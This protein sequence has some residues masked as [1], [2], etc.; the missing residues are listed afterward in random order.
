MSETRTGHAG[1]CLHTVT[2]RPWPI[3]T[4]IEKY[5]AAGIGGITIWRDAV[6]DRDTAVLRRQIQDAGL[7]VVSLCRGGFFASNELQERNAAL[8]DNRRVIELASDLGAPLVV[9]VCGADPRQ[10]LAD[11]RE[12][13]HDALVTLA[14]YAAERGV[15]LGIEPLHPMYA[16]TRSAINTLRDAR[17]LAERVGETN[18]G[19]VVDV[20]HLW[21]DPELEAELKKLKSEQLFGYHIC[22]WRVPTEHMLTDRGI[23]GEGCIPLA[24]ISTWVRETGFSGFDEVEIFSTRLWSQDQDTVLKRITEAWNG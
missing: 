15:K 12:Q 23:M 1:L 14:P 21:W 13:I 22:D 19:V 16:D 17:V 3:E 5:A 4:A 18:V 9:L 2:T 6:E 11:S 7:E 8:E 10:D 24:K 20:Y